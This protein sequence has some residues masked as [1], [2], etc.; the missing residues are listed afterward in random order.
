MCLSV[1]VH[2]QV[3]PANRSA[4][5]HPIF[6]KLQAATDT[7][8]TTSADPAWSEKL[9]EV[10]AGAASVDEEAVDLA[11][12]AAAKGLPFQARGHAFTL[13]ACLQGGAM[14]ACGPAAIAA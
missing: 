11:A 12:D 9:A 14:L 2:A 6:A 10:E 4:H 3:R 5:I 1:D 8:T 13:H 7:A